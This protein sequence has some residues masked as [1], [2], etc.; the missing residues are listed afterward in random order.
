MKKL[1]LNEL[2]QESIQ[3]I[4]SK[5][6]LFAGSV[7]T[8]EHKEDNDKPT[9][10][11]DGKLIA[12]NY[13]FFFNLSY[14]QRV[15]LIC[16]ELLHI[17]LG[18]HLRMD[19]KDEELWNAAC[20]YVINLILVEMGFAHLDNWLLDYKYKGMSAEDVYAIL[21]KQ[22][23]DQQDKQKE[24]SQES[25][26]S[27]KEPKGA[28]GQPMTDSEREAAKNAIEQEA[29]QAKSMLNRKIKGIEQSKSLTEQSKKQLLKEHG[30]GFQNYV[31]RLTDFG[32]T[33]IDWKTVIQ[34]FL[35]DKE[36]R[37]E[38]ENTFDA[39]EM[40]AQDF[41]LLIHEKES[42]AFGKVALVLDVSVSLSHIAKDVC[43][44]SF[45]C[46]GE[47]QRN[48]LTVYYVSDRIHKK[49]LI[50]DADQIKLVS[51]AGTC[52]NSFFNKELIENVDYD[53][54]GI[55]FVTDGYVNYSSWVNPEIPVLWILTQANPKFEE[56][57]PFGECVRFN[58]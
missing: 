3:L 58:K 19:G 41:N 57:V 1:S 17:L 27:F 20:D 48:E 10:Y 56:S 8:R 11:T 33:R 52:F 31:E 14:M 25:G 28:N 16:H 42:P 23:K 36:K 6:I 38:N 22:S 29:R 4:I 30:T 34:Y 7:I 9:A 40:E 53:L 45:H 15:T 44:E 5:Y 37:L 13:D 55:I 47:T 35:F 32:K 43:S 26:G 12:Y 2:V 50:T 24:Q 51:G 18:H 54:N 46:L 21:S 39:F 49:Q